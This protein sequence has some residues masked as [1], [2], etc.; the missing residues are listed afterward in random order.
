MIVAG[1]DVGSVTVKAV[2]MDNEAIVAEAVMAAHTRPAEAATAVVGRALASARLAWE[3]LACTV[4]TGYGKAMIPFAQGAESEIACHAK[5][6]W[7]CVPTARTI[8]D[9]GGQD[10]KAIRM[11][12]QG[13]VVQYRYNDKCASGTGRFLEMMAEALD[14]GLEKLGPVGATARGGLSISNQC[15][16]FAETEVVSLINAGQPVAEIIAALHQAMASRVASLA[17]GIGV[18]A[19]VVMTGGVAKN[20]GV[21]KALGLGLGADLLSLGETDPQLAGA[22][23]AAL[24]ARERATTGG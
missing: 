18:E 21:F 23:G 11:D 9:I 6:A 14:V 7:W 16:I 20:A 10:A 19:D 15:V 1:C 2:I 8:V 22:L 17:L 12:A 4:A 5:G 24:F 3:D 13:H